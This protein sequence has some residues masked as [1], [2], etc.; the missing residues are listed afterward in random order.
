MWTKTESKRSLGKK[1]E[2]L[3]AGHLSLSNPLACS[4]DGCRAQNFSVTN[5]KQFQSYRAY[6]TPNDIVK[7]TPLIV[8]VVDVLQ[9]RV[10]LSIHT[11]WHYDLAA[12]PIKKWSLHMTLT[13]YCVSVILQLR[14]KREKYSLLQ[15]E[16]F[17]DDEITYLRFDSK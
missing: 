15:T 8:T 16:M 7:N 3:Q 12:P 11:A 4:Y 5:R 10:S 17:T 2:E 9:K 14:K 13:Y 6:P 1:L